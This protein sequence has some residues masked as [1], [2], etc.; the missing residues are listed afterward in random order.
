MN[1]QCKIINT[2]GVDQIARQNDWNKTT[3]H[4]IREDRWAVAS[5]R[6]FSKKKKKSNPR[7]EGGGEGEETAYTPPPP[8]PFL[9]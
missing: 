9:G 5:L 6:H 3:R 1:F 8:F 2:D 7:A 4:E